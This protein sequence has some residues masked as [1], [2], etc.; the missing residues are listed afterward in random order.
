MNFMFFSKVRPLEFTQALLDAGFNE[1]V[2]ITISFIWEI[3]E[4]G[5]QS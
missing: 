4:I 3:L 5:G 1:A 2:T